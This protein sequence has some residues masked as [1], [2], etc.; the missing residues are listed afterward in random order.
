MPSSTCCVAAVRGDWCPTTC[1]PGAPSI[2][3]F[4]AGATEASGIRSYKLCAWRCAPSKAEILSRQRPALTVNPSKPVQCVAPK[5]AT[6]RGKKIWG[7]KRHILVDTQG[8]LLVV[9]VTGAHQSDQQ[10]AKTLL[11]PLKDTFPK[12][13]LL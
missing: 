6:M 12:I 10:G 11:T 13:K 7:R 1:Q 3:I 5:K 4:D 2:G 9:K 8:H